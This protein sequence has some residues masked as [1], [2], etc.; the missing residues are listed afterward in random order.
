M[1]LGK[2]R[3]R[4]NPLKSADLD[5]VSRAVYSSKPSIAKSAPVRSDGGATESR[6]GSI[7]WH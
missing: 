2:A 3:V 6:A 7:P 4:R 5:R 1:N